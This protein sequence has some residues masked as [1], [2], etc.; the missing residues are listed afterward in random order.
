MRDGIVWIPVIMDDYDLHK[1]RMNYPDWECRL[2]SKVEAARF[3]AVGL[4]DCYAGYWLE[5]YGGLLSKLK[6]M[7]ELRTMDEVANRV[8]LAG[9]S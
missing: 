2:L 8:L 3:A 9:A 1:K 4:H 6:K 7:G 5:H